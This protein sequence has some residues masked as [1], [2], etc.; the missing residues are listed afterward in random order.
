MS[1][2]ELLR[3]IEAIANM[4]PSSV[5]GSEPLEELADWDSLAVLS[6]I[7]LFDKEFGVIL[8]PDKIG[9]CRNIDDIIALAG[10]GVTA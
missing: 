10:D 1:R 7:S 6:V 9:G 4:D 3:R 2:D 5:D 8:S